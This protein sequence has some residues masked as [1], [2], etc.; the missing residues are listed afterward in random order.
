MFTY[1][2]GI[3]EGMGMDV[4]V[5]AGV[6]VGIGVGEDEGAELVTST[7]S[8]IMLIKRYIY[9]LSNLCITMNHILGNIYQE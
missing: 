9:I 6:D 2:M 4:G 8:K 7:K 1:S 3:V 5:G